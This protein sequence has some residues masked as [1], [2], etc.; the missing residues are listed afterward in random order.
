MR[1]LALLCAGLLGAC[2]AQPAPPP[3]DPIPLG[4]GRVGVTLNDTPLELE[5]YRPAG[6]TPRLVLLVFHGIA[7]NAD[8]YRDFARPLAD[9][10][11]AV[12]VAPTFDQIRFPRALYQYGG[13]AEYPPGRRSIDF[14]PLLAAWTREH[15]GRADLPLV[16]LGHSAGAQFLSRVAAFVPTGAAAII[17]ANPSSWVLPSTAVAA[18][19]GLGR[20]PQGTQAGLSTYLGLPL[21][22]L[23]GGRDTGPA[24]LDVSPEAMRQGPNRLARGRRAYA[25]A[26]RAAAARGLPLG[27][28]LTEVPGVG[29]DA[30]KM[31]ASPQALEAVRRAVPDAGKP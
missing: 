20:T 2:A 17:I 22:V 6:C 10:T 18:P 5:T 4:S 25:M 14:V 26:R 24:H 11:C 23:L 3:P 21:T 15:L 27:W 31:F 7:R 16:L 29:H 9:A 1:L 12:V 30:A 19:F 8:A 28:H 13:V